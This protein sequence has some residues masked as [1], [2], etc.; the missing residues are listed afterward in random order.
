MIQTCDFN[1]DSVYEFTSLGFFRKG[2]N[3][4]PNRH[5][6]QKESMRE[7]RNSRKKLKVAEE[8]FLFGRKE[9]I[10]VLRV[11]LES[12]SYVRPPH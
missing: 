12:F 8:P 4:K 7:E 3:L 5:L 2:L 10:R 11:E 6:K 9:N 1:Y